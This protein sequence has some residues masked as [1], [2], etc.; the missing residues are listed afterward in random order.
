MPPEARQPAVRLI[1]GSAWFGLGLVVAFLAGAAT[2]VYVFGQ[3][4]RMKGPHTTFAMLAWLAPVIAL[5]AT[6]VYMIG[7][8]VW[9]FAPS[10]CLALLAGMSI[11]GSFWLM[12][13]SGR[14][15][16]GEIAIPLTWLACLGGS[17]LA[18]RILR[19]WKRRHSA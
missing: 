13:S 2:S 7:V 15:L 17:F 16:P 1:S 3:V 12:A 5:V 8:R 4:E 14:F 9:A 10:G 6:A 19:G 11:A 18:P